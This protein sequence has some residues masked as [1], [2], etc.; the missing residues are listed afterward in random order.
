MKDSTED[1]AKSEVGSHLDINPEATYNSLLTHLTTAFQTSETFETL[2][3]QIYSKTQK[4]KEMFDEIQN[5]GRRI[6]AVNPEWRKEANAA[7]KQL[8]TGMQDLV[9]QPLAR[10]HLEAS[11][12]LSYTSFRAKLARLFGTRL[13][14]K[15]TALLTTTKGQIKEIISEAI[16]SGSGY[17]ITASTQSTAISQETQTDI[18][19]RQNNPRCYQGNSY[20]QGNVIPGVDGKTWQYTAC[21]YCKNKGHIA[22][23]CPKLAAKKARDAQK[24]ENDQA[25]Q[26][27]NHN[28]QWTN[29]EN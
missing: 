20:N 3:A 18:P 13:K 14:G 9:L 17:S 12:D 22:R 19:Q 8:V 28:Q 25:N 4:V 27:S 15:Q 1:S 29:S 26:Q 24:Q 11:V 21:N 23:L 16:S 2:I 7:M 10:T 5:L 6:I